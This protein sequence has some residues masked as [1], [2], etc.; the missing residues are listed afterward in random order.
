MPLNRFDTVFGV[1][2]QV[3]GRTVYTD[4]RI[5]SVLP[6]SIP[7]GGTVGQ[8]LVFRTEHTVVVLVIH[9]LPPLVPTLH[10][11]R[12]LVGGG[13]RTSIF[14]YL[15]TDIRGLVGGIG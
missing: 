5:T 9:I 15:F 2:A 13:E 12:T 4:A 1:G 14:K 8:H 10:G 6:V 11:L 7:V 3:A